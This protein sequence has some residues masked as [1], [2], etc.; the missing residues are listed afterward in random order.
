M[1]AILAAAAFALVATVP[2]AAQD[3]GDVE[4]ADPAGP[5][6]PDAMADDSDE[7][8]HGLTGQMTEK[9]ETLIASPMMDMPLRE[10]VGRMGL[11][12]G[13]IDELG[14]GTM[15]DMLAGMDPAAMARM[16]QTLP[17]MM[18]AMPALIKAVRGMTAQMAPPSGTSDDDEAEPNESE[19]Y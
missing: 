8:M 19:D 9:F 18:E 14:Q 11:G 5:M 3:M 7:T 4:Y 15:R 13:D 2:A 16:K 6:D 1:K 12:Q 10:L 17:R